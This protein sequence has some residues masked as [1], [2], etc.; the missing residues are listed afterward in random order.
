MGARFHCNDCEDFDLCGDC[1]RK[2]THEHMMEKIEKSA[3][4]AQ[5]QNVVNLLVQPLNGSG[6]V[7]LKPPPSIDQVDKPLTSKS[8][9][10]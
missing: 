7:S 3:K 2:S 9:I 4:S 1:Y 8:A 6:R 5:L 10:R